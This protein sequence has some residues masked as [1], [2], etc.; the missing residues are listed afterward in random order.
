MIDSISDG[1]ELTHNREQFASNLKKMAKDNKIA[2]SLGQFFSLTEI[3]RQDDF[4][5]KLKCEN[6]RISYHG[7]ETEPSND[8]TPNQPHRHRRPRLIKSATL[9]THR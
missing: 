7:R 9:I 2:M 6:G 1:P 3:A 5:G 8:H 4:G